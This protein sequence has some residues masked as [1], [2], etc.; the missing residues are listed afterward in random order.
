MADAIILKFE[1]MPV[2]IKSYLYP[3]TE[4]VVVLYSQTDTDWEQFEPNNER[5]V[6]NMQELVNS[7]I[8]SRIPNDAG[9][10][11]LEELFFC[12]THRWLVIGTI[13]AIGH[14]ANISEDVM[15]TFEI[16]NSFETEKD[17]YQWDGSTY[18][19]L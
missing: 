1:Y 4:S 13:T 5:V 15:F 11:N 12:S 17:R 9:T 18:S 10:F 7:E 3:N 14:G 16:W 8:I 19:I 2:S 6:K